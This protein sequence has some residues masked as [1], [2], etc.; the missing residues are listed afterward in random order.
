[1]IMPKQF[2]LMKQDDPLLNKCLKHIQALPNLEVRNSHLE[3]NDVDGLLTIRSSINSVNY[4]YTIQPDITANSI[5]L[6]I[7]Y[8]KLLKEKFKHN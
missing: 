6:V 3:T 7:R 8:F 4:A 1:M 2:H 5:K